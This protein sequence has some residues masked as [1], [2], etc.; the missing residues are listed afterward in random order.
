MS[1]LDA[2]KSYKMDLFKVQLNLD[3]RVYSA[4]ACISVWQVSCHVL[5]I[6][7]SQEQK[8]TIVA[9]FIYLFIFLSPLCFSFICLNTV[10]VYLITVY[11]AVVL[12]FM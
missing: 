12:D 3:C 5:L 1:T 7:Q 2:T 4:P 10:P 8:R 9:I 11:I 6:G